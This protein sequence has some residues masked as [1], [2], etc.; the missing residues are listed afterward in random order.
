MKFQMPSLEGTRVAGAQ[1]RTV[2]AAA[3]VMVLGAL[4]L[5]AF[6]CSQSHTVPSEIEESKLETTMVGSYTYNGKTVEVNAKQVIEDTGSI[7]AMKRSDGN[8]SAPSAEMVLNYTR[9]AVMRHLVQDEKISVT[10][11]QINK[12]LKDNLGYDSVETVASQ[13]GMSTEQATTIAKETT[14][15]AELK[16]KIVGEMTE[17]APQPPTAPAQGSE[18]KATEAYAQYIIKLAGDQ[19]D[20]TTGAFKDPNGT[21]A[22][23]LTDMPFDGKTATYL[24]A[25]TAYYVAYS[26]FEPTQTEHDKK[27]TDYVNKALSSCQLTVYSITS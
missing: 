3:T 17:K 6:G 27:W 19:W 5:S 16:K 14:E 4:A 21:Y 2:R 1:V 22:Q 12:F 18:E 15:T 13:F 8:I 23:A 10:D 11:D 26:A 9:N 20:A 7:E 25:Q 24:Q